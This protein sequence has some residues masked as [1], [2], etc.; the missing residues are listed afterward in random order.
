MWNVNFFKKSLK[1]TVQWWLPYEGMGVWRAWTYT[2]QR[3]QG[4]SQKTNEH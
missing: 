1:E 3:A 4:F 2:G